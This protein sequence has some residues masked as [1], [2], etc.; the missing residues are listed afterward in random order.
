[1]VGYKNKTLFSGEYFVALFSHCAFFSTF[2]FNCTFI[3][4]IGT[5]LRKQPEIVVV[6]IVGTIEE[7]IGF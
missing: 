2:L 1:M 7:E 4:L 6:L 5:E 3:S